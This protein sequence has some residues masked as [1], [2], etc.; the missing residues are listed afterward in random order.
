MA[1]KNNFNQLVVWQGTDLGDTDPKELVDFFIDNLDT[2]IKWC[3]QV[4]TLPD[5]IDGQKVEGTGGR[6]DLLF[7]VHNEDISKFALKRFQLDGC[8]WWEDVVSYNNQAHLYSQEI[9]DKY[10]VNW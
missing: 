8:R 4:T 10:K 5:V 1:Q 3:E 2:R 6:F 7:Y 9:L